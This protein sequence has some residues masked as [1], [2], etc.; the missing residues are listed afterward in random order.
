[1]STGALDVMVDACILDMD[2]RSMVSLI[3]ICWCVKMLL[4]KI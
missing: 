2:L 4:F 3:F 1:M